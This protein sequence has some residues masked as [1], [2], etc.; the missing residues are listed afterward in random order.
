MKVGLW[1]EIR[2]LKEVEGLSQRAIAQR[3]GCCHKT[4]KKALAMDQPPGRNPRCSRASLLD[5]YKQQ[6][7]ALL[8]KSPELSAVRV[9][10]EIRR[11]DHGYHGGIS[12]VR[13]YLRRI[14]R[15][16]GRIYQEVDW[17]P[18]EALQ[19]DW[20][21]CGRIR[22]GKIWRRIY[23]FVAVLCY[24]RLCYIEFSL[25]QR[26]A[27][28][29]RA[30]VHALEFIGGLPRKL[31]FDNLKAA[32]LN[33]SGRTACLHPEFLALCGHYCLE[34]VPCAR[35]DPESK[36]MVEAGVRYVKRNA[37]AGREEELTRWEDYGPLAV[38][39]RDQVANVRLHERTRE[40]PVDRFEKERPLLRPL[41][42]IPF[43]TDEIVSAL[44]SPLAQI[45]FDGNRYSVPPEA[46][47]QTVIV[48]ANAAQVCVIYQGRELACHLRSYERGQRITQEEHQLATL[49]L[50]QR[51][52]AR[53]VERLFDDL[54]PEAR[55]FHLELRRRPVKTTVHLRRMLNLVRLYGRAEV[56]AAIT[57]AHQYQTY[58]AAYVEALVLQEQRR[59]ELPSPTPLC[60]Q[61]PELLEESD[62]EEPDPAT[63]D[64]LCQDQDSDEE[65]EERHDGQ[66][67]TP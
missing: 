23:V 21:E 61:R 64:A 15:P 13:R 43:D 11:G 51:T 58:D 48:R 4:V 49:Q 10:E 2:R 3:L 16:R 31:I 27:D 47:R 37:L 5:P 57:L 35:R 40:R 12:L 46:A 28:F 18:G 17:Q 7:D 54:G 38:Y 53:G 29:Y 44:V 26:K 45:E 20:G 52:R 1:A 24:S 32:V 9:L 42:A 60:P 36:G 50:R 56:L 55:A 22:V 25:A 39:W 41:P 65:P 66:T 59:R 30:L 34:A 67:E 63:Y 33:G 19:V 8:A 62:F 14:R 6:I